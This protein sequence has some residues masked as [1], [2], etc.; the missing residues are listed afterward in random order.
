MCNEIVQGV[1]GMWSWRGEW[2][3]EHPGMDARLECNHIACYT[4]TTKALFMFR[5]SPVKK[6]WHH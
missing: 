3:C 1:H 4:C 6:H 2:R 5:T